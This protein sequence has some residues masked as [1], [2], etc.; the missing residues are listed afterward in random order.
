MADELVLELVRQLD[1]AELAGARHLARIAAL[2]AA[3]APGG[4]AEA[5]LR[6]TVQQLRAETR[7][8][9]AAAA[10]AQH[11]AAAAAEALAA[12]RARIAALE[13][14]LAAKAAGAPEPGTA[15]AAAAVPDADSCSV[16][17]GRT[18]SSRE[19]AGL[20][21]GWECARTPDGA[22]YYIECGPPGARAGA[23]AG[24][25]TAAPGA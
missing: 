8:E 24:G 15:I 9:R 13:A 16:R 5:A 19:D 20:P 14:Q 10:A 6:A 23:R 2:E 17:S 18:A 1:A 4:E 12:A 21:P 3:A 25:L 22:V 7:R 11:A